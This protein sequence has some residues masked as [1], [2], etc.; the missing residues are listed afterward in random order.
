MDHEEFRNNVA[1]YA[2]GVLDGDERVAL[3]QHLAHCAECQAEYRDS[4][5]VLQTVGDTLVEPDWSGHTSLRES[6]QAR[7]AADTPRRVTPVTTRMSEP[8]RVARS[9]WWP[10]AWVA[11]L[12]VAVGGW[13]A[14]YQTGQQLKHV[15]A[16]VNVQAH[17]LRR[18]EVIL[19]MATAGRPVHLSPLNAPNSQVDLYLAKSEALV[20]VKKL[21][22]LTPGHIYEGWWII[23]GS[24]VPAGTFGTGPSVLHL[25][26]GAQAFAITIEPQGGTSHPTTPVLASANL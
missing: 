13:T 25:P 21:P 15:E 16:G 26:S 23:N 19:G 1:L 5:A 11:T 4:L 2:A 24:A 7:L 18:A 10:L 8:R 20:W 6:F 9:R 3:E 12:L 17:A 14:A 22:V